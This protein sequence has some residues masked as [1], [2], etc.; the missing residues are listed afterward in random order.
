MSAAELKLQII[1]KV[2]AIKDKLI[3]EEIH[4]IVSLELAMDSVYQLTDA[5]RTAVQA[6]LADAKEGRVHSSEAAEGL[7]REWLKK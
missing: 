3:L 6:G 5:E 7:L 2:S 4:K 1:N